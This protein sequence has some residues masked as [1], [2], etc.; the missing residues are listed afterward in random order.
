MN[1]RINQEQPC[2]SNIEMRLSNRRD[3]NIDNQTSNEWTVNSDVVD[4][5]SI[6]SYFDDCKFLIPPL[7]V[8]FSYHIGQDF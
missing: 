3:Q 8:R 2:V 1:G 4:S 6:L 5:F 7:F